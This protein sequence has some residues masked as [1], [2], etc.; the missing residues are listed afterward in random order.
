MTKWI[1]LVLMFIDH[2]GQTFEYFMSPSMYLLLRGLGRLSFPLFVY[3]VVLGVQRT[4][5]IKKYIGRMFFFGVVSEIIMR[6][7]PVFTFERLNVLFGFVLY[8]IFYMIVLDKKSKVSEP[9]KYIMWFVF[10]FLSSFTDYS[11]MG[12]FLFIGL[13]YL[14]IIDIE[15]K[16]VYSI[17]VIFTVFLPDSIMSSGVPIQ[18][19]AVFAGPLM[20]SDKLDKRLFSPAIEKWV[21]YLAYPLQWILLGLMI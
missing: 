11:Y 2:Y 4:S 19:L 3:F 7:Y 21:F 8:G 15:K 10:A 16:G 14:S 5:D 9:V 6:S 13:Y 1:A 20:F 17:F 12:F 18:M